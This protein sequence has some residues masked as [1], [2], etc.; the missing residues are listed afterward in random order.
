MTDTVETGD[1]NTMSSSD[2]H[3]SSSSS[4]SSSNNNSASTHGSDSVVLWQPTATAATM[5]LA[6]GTV[7]R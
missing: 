7:C 5:A 4:S 1:V 6:A 3:N 2:D